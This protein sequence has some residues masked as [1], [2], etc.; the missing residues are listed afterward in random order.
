M[1]HRDISVVALIQRDSWNILLQD[2]RN[3]KRDTVEWGMFWGGIEGWETP[4]VAGIREIQEELN[5]ALVAD[6]MIYVG[7]TG[8]EEVDTKTYHVSIFITFWKE[9]YTE[10]MQVL[11]WAGAGWFTFPEARLLHGYPI[12]QAHFSIIENYITRFPLQNNA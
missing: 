4:L 1:Q 5:I 12:D 10:T 6:D 8:Y 7:S 11:E 2:R 9:K 3:I